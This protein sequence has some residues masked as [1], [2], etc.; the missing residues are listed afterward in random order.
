MGGK[1]LRLIT[2]LLAVSVFA[3]GAS[4]VL[5]GGGKGGGK[6]PGVSNPKTTVII[7]YIDPVDAK[8]GN[9]KGKKP[10]GEE[11]TPE[12]VKPI[13]TATLT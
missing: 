6:P 4:P 13:S 5:G 7:D 11:P 1:R 2:V 12:P 10:P 9:G 8:G 3:F